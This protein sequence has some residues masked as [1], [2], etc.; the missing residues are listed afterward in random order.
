[1]DDIYSQDEGYE[2]NFVYK[3]PA[4]ADKRETSGRTDNATSE[5][6]DSNQVP[7]TGEQDRN[8]KCKNKRSGDQCSET[9]N[10]KVSTT[11]GKDTTLACDEV[12]EMFEEEVY[13]RFKDAYAKIHSNPHLEMTL[14]MKPID[15]EL[16]RIGCFPFLSRKA[17]QEDPDNKKEYYQMLEISKIRGMRVFFEHFWAFADKILA[18]RGTM[19]TTIFADVIVD[20]IEVFQVRDLTNNTIV[21]GD[22]TERTVRHV[23]R[24]E[25]D[26]GMV[27]DENDEHYSYKGNW[28]IADIDDIFDNSQWAL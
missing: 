23:V 24:M 25:L 17:V 8:D 26:I 10:E 16:W 6:R 13:K 22:G 12:K 1:M 2:V 19:E 3:T 27:V 14:K 28:R 11:G 20:C 4:H 5:S 15:S 18:E 9:I 21:Q 7:L